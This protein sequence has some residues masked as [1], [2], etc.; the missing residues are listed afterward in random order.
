MI[1]ISK[2][3]DY[4]SPKK[5]FYNKVNQLSFFQQLYA[6]FLFE[7]IHKY[8]LFIFHF[9]HYTLIYLIPYFF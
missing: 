5:T 8:I 9:I 4:M 6:L 2:R 7:A 3:S 1:R